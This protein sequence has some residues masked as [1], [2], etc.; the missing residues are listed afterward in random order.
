ME[1]RTYDGKS[2]E[3]VDYKEKAASGRE[4]QDCIFTQCNF[5]GSNFSGSKFIDCTFAG[6]NLSLLKLDQ[7]TL[8]NVI[9]KDCKILGVNFH[10]C[11]AFLFSVSFDGCVLDFASFAG[12]KMPKTNFIKCSLKETSFMQTILTGSKFDQCDLAGTIFN[13]TDL[14]NC[15]LVT[16]YNYQIDPEINKLNKASFAEHG[17]AGLLFKYGIKV[18]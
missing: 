7:S 10:E 9:F 5:S 1:L 14:S 2:F 17:L 6:C 13:R 12:R 8:S 15:N 11:S 4:F 16:A 18:V 3:K